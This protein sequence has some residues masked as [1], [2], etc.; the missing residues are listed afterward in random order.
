MTKA[1]AVAVDSFDYIDANGEG[2]HVSEGNAYVGTIDYVA[3]TFSFVQ[4]VKGRRFEVVAPIY[5]D[6]YT[7]HIICNANAERTAE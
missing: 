3:E 1:V 2:F 5:S 4:V 7:F 6:R